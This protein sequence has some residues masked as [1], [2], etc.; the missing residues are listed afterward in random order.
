MKKKKKE[1]TPFEEE[2]KEDIINRRPSNQYVSTSATGNNIEE[3]I[4][5]ERIK[6]DCRV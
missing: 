3:N 2:A 4:I 1:K 5:D 6:V